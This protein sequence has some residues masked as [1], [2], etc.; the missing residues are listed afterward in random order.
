MPRRAAH[1]KARRPGLQ[2]RCAARAE[3]AARRAAGSL[4]SCREVNGQRPVVVPHTLRPAAG[5]AVASASRLLP[6]AVELPALL[7]AGM[8]R[9]RFAPSD[10][11]SAGGNSLEALSSLQSLCSQLGEWLIDHVQ[12]AAATT[13][14]SGDCEEGETVERNGDC[15]AQK[16]RISEPRDPVLEIACLLRG[17]KLKGE[18]LRGGRLIPDDHAP[19]ACQAYPADGSGLC[20]G[21]ATRPSGLR[22]PVSSNW[23]TPLHK[24]LHPASG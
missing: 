9:Q 7:R 14:T 2:R 6:Q 19:T 17:K 23:I 20:G 5:H 24:R 16:L 11:R 4:G 8:R 18:A 22:H 13:R 10:V 21:S 1:Q 15:V 12:L 3:T